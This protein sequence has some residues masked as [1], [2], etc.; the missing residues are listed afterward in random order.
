M[1]SPVLELQH[2]TL[3]QSTPVSALL[4]MAHALAYKLK[5]TETSSW[6]RSEL[7]GYSDS[8][9]PEYRR[10]SVLVE[11]F[12]PYHGWQTINFLDQALEDAYRHEIMFDP[13]AVL[14]GLAESVAREGGQASKR[15]STEERVFIQR[16]M[17]VPMDVRSFVDI[18]AIRNILDAAR[19]RILNW[20]L[21]LESN[22]VLGDGMSFTDQEKER[23]S[24]SDTNIHIG[25]IGAMTGNVG[26]TVHSQ[27]ID[28]GAV[29]VGQLSD[30]ARSF[31][32]DLRPRVQ[33]LAQD[34]AAPVLAGH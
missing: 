11:A 9:V 23:A 5:L 31:L 32:A 8:N 18:A 21:E 1:P 28:M 34:E 17:P 26:G 15:L 14:E 6:I 7:E 27:A 13:V 2:A 25:S 3:D 24:S 33:V 29:P 30:R 10:V 22:G 16:Q 19:T 20:A 4:R 12:N